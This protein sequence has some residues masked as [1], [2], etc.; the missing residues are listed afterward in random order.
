M[1]KDKPKY[2]AIADAI[3]QDIQNAVFKP[4]ERLPTE[5][6]LMDRFEVSRMT[7]RHAISELVRRKVAHTQKRQGVY[8]SDLDIRRSQ[9][10]LGI[11]ELFARKGIVCTSVVNRLEKGLPTEE[12]KAALNLKDDEPI[13][14]LYRTRYAKDE[15]VLIEYVHIAAKFCPG[16]EMFNFEKYSLYDILF[17]HYGLKMAWAK[18][19]IRAEIIKGHEAQT[20]LKAKSGPALTV[21]NVSYNDQDIPVEYTRLIYNHKVFTYTVISTEISSKYQSGSQ[22]R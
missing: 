20:L 21:T 13:Y 12:A 11:T 16:L 1:K 22:N 4:G 7:I 19:D 14:Y 18:D 8:V 17:E 5:Y 2:I 10:I 15:A 6:E 9:E 3:A